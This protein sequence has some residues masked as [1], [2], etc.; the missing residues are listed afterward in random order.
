MCKWQRV[1]VRCRN[2]HNCG[3]YAQEEDRRVVEGCSGY[4]EWQRLRSE[5][6][7][8]VGPVYNRHACTSSRQ[9]DDRVDPG[10]SRRYCTR[11]APPPRPHAQQVAEY[12][13]RPQSIQGPAGSLSGASASSA[14]PQPSPELL[15]LLSSQTYADFSRN[16]SV[17]ESQYSAST[18]VSDVGATSGSI[19]SIANW[20]V[21]SAYDLMP[22]PPR[23]SKSASYGT[24][25]RYG[26]HYTSSQYL[27]IPSPPRRPSRRYGR[28]ETEI[29]YSSRAADRDENE[30]RRSSHAS[31]AQTEDFYP[32]TSE[33]ESPTVQRRSEHAAYHTYG[34]GAGRSAYSDTM[35]GPALTASTTQSYSLTPAVYV[36]AD[37]RRRVPIEDMEDQIEE[38]P[39]RR[40]QRLRQREALVEGEKLTERRQRRHHRS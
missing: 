1:R 27:R 20:G 18:T 8:R 28:P 29:Q 19:G 38:Q 24:G 33:P 13:E 36:A 39:V 10:R 25:H 14:E 4:I 22:P 16:S 32:A 40:S 6:S 11:C 21:R 17:T 23:S 9:E 15:R 7:D 37:A 31:E 30:S 3:R 2:F 34:T 26:S 35:F 5:G 12:G